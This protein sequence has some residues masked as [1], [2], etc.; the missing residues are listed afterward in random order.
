MRNSTIKKKKNRNPEDVMLTM[1]ANSEEN[2]NTFKFQDKLKMTM[3]T[4]KLRL[5]EDSSKDTNYKYSEIRH[6]DSTR[7]STK[8][9]RKNDYLKTNT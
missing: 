4:N 9:K 5:S 7:H 3:D 2:S 1:G 8:T 6:D